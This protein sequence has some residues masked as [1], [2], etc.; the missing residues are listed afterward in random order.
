M[1]FQVHTTKGTNLATPC[2]DQNLMLTILGSQ[3][4]GVGKKKQKEKARRHVKG[5]NAESS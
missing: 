3:Q 4:H 5:N 2:N 1:E